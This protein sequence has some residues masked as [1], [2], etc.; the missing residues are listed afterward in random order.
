M[1]GLQS[2]CPELSLL[3]AA[4]PL[5]AI[6]VRI[7]KLRQICFTNLFIYSIFWGFAKALVSMLS[8]RV[9]IARTAAIYLKSVAKVLKK[10]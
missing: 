6:R 4:L 2:N 3:L 9:L 10:N 8:L 1:I 7:D 5:R